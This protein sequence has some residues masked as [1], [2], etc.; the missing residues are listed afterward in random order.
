AGV[1]RDAART[2]AGVAAQP[3]SGASTPQR[4]AAAA[5]DRAAAAAAAGRSGAAEEQPENAESAA[6]A[7]IDAET[8]PADGSEGDLR[9]GGREDLREQASG[10]PRQAGLPAGG[11]PAAGPRDGD[12]QARQPQQGPSQKGDQGQSQGSGQRSGQ[13]QGGQGQ[14]EDE[15]Q[16]RAHGMSGLL[17]GVPMQDQLTGTANRGRVRSITRPGE[18]AAASAEPGQVQARGSGQGDAGG[19]AHRAASAAEERL[20][21]DYFLRQRT[22][23][24]GNEEDH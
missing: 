21:R 22:A 9:D 14:G 12:E 2:A 18:P 17:L 13:G 3:G 8:A 15:A 24:G 23:A 7:S 11:Q 1:A 6:S 16:K 10:S 5:D 4:P 19:I 20:V